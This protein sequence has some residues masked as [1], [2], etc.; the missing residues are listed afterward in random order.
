MSLFASRP[1]ATN[2]HSCTT[3]TNF[4]HQ[5]HPDTGSNPTV[6]K[7]QFKPESPILCNKTKS[8]AKSRKGRKQTNWYFREGW[9]YARAS[10]DTRRNW[11]CSDTVWKGSQTRQLRLGR[12]PTELITC[13]SKGV[14][15]HWEPRG[16]HRAF[17]YLL[18]RNGP[19]C[20]PNTP[21]Q[22]ISPFP[23][24]SLLFAN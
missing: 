17:M 6:W 14:R 13:N 15:M 10:C 1:C 8:C 3:S 23:A 7:C 21:H 11:S 18:V 20:Q 4:G 12:I 22:T 5:I 19:A 2:P 24:P 16:I 9:W